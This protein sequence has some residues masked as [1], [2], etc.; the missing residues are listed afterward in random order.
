MNRLEAIR[1]RRSVRA[2]ESEALKSEDIE[3]LNAF[4]EKIENPYGIPVRFKILNAKEN[5]LTSP[6]ASS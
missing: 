3:K 6:G 2:F 1:G 4:A 5:G